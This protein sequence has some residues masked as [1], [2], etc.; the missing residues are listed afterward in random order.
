MLE[1]LNMFTKHTKT[2]QAPGT[3][4]LPNLHKRSLRLCALKGKQQYIGFYEFKVYENGVD[5]VIPTATRP[6]A[7]LVAG[8]AAY[9]TSYG[10]PA[11]T[12][13]GVTSNWTSTCYVN[14]NVNRSVFIQYNF[15]RQ[16]NPTTWGLLCEGAWQPDIGGVALLM[17]TNAG[18]VD[19]TG[20]VSPAGAW[21][22]N[23]WHTF[24]NLGVP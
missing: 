22:A 21:A 1:L 9:G 10:D 11:A 16:I 23:T 2:V 13:D 19:I 18:W 6:T 7:E 3:V 8:G 12:I 24:S 14:T 4:S 15:P 20:T 5:L 17:Y